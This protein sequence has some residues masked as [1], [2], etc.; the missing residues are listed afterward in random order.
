MI[1]DEAVNACVFR[2]KGR[3]YT[4]TVIQLLD[5]DLAQFNTHL[6]AVVARAPKM[7]EDAPV[8][9]DVSAVTDQ[10]L[11]FLGIEHCLQACGM[12]LVAIQGANAHVQADAKAHGLALLH[13]SATH[14]K[15]LVTEPVPVES[16]TRPSKTIL[17]PVRSGQQIVSKG[18]DLVVLGAVGH[19]AEVLADGHI[20][21][22][23]PLRGRALAGLDGDRQARIFCQSLEAELV[24]I[25][26][27]YCLSDAMP[28]ITG[29]CQIFLQDDHVKFEAL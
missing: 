8:V 13:A 5:V 15:T 26:G 9:L 29:P 23:G 6:H 16:L 10:A 12:R 18:G 4:L 19:G 25:A 21:V 17:L 24:S 1:V 28:S 22:Y 7:F 14:D 11:D 20:H 27:F 2:L 3:L